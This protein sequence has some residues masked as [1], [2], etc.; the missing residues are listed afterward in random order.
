MMLARCSRSAKWLRSSNTKDK[1]SS[2]SR[3]PCMPPPTFSRLA[4]FWP[5]QR[6]SFA[7]ASPS[8]T[9]SSKSGL[10]ISSTMQTGGKASTPEMSL[11]SPPRKLPMSLISSIGG[12]SAR[13]GSSSTMQAGYN[14]S[15]PPSNAVVSMLLQPTPSS[16][17]VE[18]RARSSARAFF[19]IRAVAI[20]RARSS[21]SLCCRCSLRAYHADPRRGVPRFLG[22][23]L[24]AVQEKY[25]DR[26]ADRNQFKAHASILQGLQT[27]NRAETGTKR[28][29]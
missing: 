2:R 17:M 5:S 1:C 11:Q 24:R 27:D 9:A 7:V 25:T 20:A 19:L 28:N 3:G 18:S 8:S 6:P 22:M 13:V 12:R 21:C 16:A 15:L 10:G 4:S 14:C 23:V 29:S 26:D